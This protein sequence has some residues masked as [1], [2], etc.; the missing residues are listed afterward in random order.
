[1]WVIVVLPGIMTM[2]V[3]VVDIGHIW[4]ARNELKNALDAAALSGIKTWGESGGGLTTQARLDANDAMSANTILGTTTTLDT[5]VGACTNEN[6][7]STG[8]IVFGSVTDS[9]ATITLDCSVAPSCPADT[10]GIRT[11]KTIEVRSICPTFLGI[12][13]GPYGVTAESF[14]RFTCPSGPPQLIRLDTF[15]CVCP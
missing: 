7:A 8:E 10:F 9:G 3:A 12:G 4:L 11:R 15:T 13:L 5:T 2:F 14:A 6:V 1:M